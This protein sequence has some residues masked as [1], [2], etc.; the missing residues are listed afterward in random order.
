MFIGHRSYRMDV[1]PLVDDETGDDRSRR[2]RRQVDEGHGLVT[3]AGCQRVDVK[4]LERRQE[5]DLV[6]AD[7]RIEQPDDVKAEYR[8]Q[9]DGD[10]RFYPGQ[11]R[12]EQEAERLSLIHISEPTRLRRI[13][14]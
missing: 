11:H 8:G 14:Y 1:L 4:E 3:A 7:D 13:S 5:L 9:G 6:D 10:H 2:Q 12:T